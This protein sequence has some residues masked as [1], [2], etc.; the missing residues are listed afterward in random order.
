M[1]DKS[2][3]LRALDFFNFFN[4]GIQTGLGPFIAIYYATDRHWNP[5][6]IGAVLSIQ[7]LMGVLTQSFIGHF[8]DE[9]RYKRTVAAVAA[10]AVVA[11]S[12]GIVFLRSFVLQ[13]VT[14]A[15]IGVAVTVF[16]AATSAFALGMVEQK[17]VSARVARNESFTH[18]GNV[19]FAIIAAALGLTIAVRDIF[20]VAAVFAAGMGACAYLIHQQDVNYEAAR[21]AAS[22]SEGQESDDGEKD[23]GKKKDKPKAKGWRELFSDKRVIIFTL[24]VVLF[25]V[26]NTSTLPLVGQLL[27][28][29]GKSAPVWQ[30]AACVIVAEVVMV[31]VAWLVGK[32]VNVWGRKPIFLAAFAVLALRNGL[33]VVSHQQ[34]YLISLQALDGIAAAIYGVLLTLVTADLARGTGRLNF[35]QGSVQSAM[36]LGGFLSNM[37]FGWVARAMGFNIAFLGLAAGAAAGG[38]L[39]WAKMPE[40][41]TEENS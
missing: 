5:G 36:G 20:F 32:R 12:L 38:A 11:G 17:E 13:C 23:D 30:T 6:Q 18:A 25:N 4:A 1:P 7:S 14:Q 3:S 34:D 27:S 28:H 2:Q 8:Y 15:V 24:T 9:T 31:V 29:G 19:L 35:L 33:T 41:K 21:A 10:L 16:P 39:Y 26:G 22:G 40:T 37:A